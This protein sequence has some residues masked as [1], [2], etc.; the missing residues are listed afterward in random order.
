LRASPAPDRSFFAFLNTNKRG[1]TLN[2]ESTQGQ[3]L[4][5]ALASAIYRRRELHAGITDDRRAGYDLLG[6][7]GRA[8][9]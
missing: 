5:R 2:L 6:P 8:S 3:A 4:F 1:M 9:S 7:P